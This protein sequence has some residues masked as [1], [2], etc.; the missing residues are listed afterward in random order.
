MSKEIATVLL[1]LLIASALFA[2]LAALLRPA[3]TGQPLPERYVLGAG[4]QAQLIGAPDALDA[5]AQSLASGAAWNASASRV[6]EPRAGGAYL[7]G[8]GFD[9]L[10]QTARTR[11]LKNSV[12][13]AA[14]VHIDARTVGTIASKHD[15]ERGR[16]VDLKVDQTGSIL[17]HISDSTHVIYLETNRTF[18][19]G[20]VH[21][22]VASLNR[23]DAVLAVDGAV[24][25]AADARHVE[26]LLINAPFAIGASGAQELPTDYFTGILYDV[27]IEQP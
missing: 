18:R 1:V 12:R 14:R 17:F 22:V 9:L 11:L 20:R 26:P 10:A 24:E 16:W 3:E 13:I 2:G 8:T 7:D 5:L 19:D 21:R 6:A 27:D 23:T 15:R 25:A 4:L